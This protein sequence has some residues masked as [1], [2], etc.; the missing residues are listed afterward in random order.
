LSDC[1]IYPTRAE[2]WNLELLETMSMNRPVI[3]TNY[4]SQTEFCN[5][6][7][8]FLVSVDSLE[9]AFDNKAFRNQGSWAKIS[10][11]EKD[12]FIDFMR[13]VYKNRINTNAEGIKTAQTYTWSHTAELIERCMLE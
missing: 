13:F 6:D 10:H 9:S 2:G 12:N 5:K 4:S 8:S 7:N 3:T 11:K 1:G